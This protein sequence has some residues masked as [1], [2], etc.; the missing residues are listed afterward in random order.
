MRFCA[1]IRRR[2]REEQLEMPATAAPATV[3]HTPAPYPST[4]HTPEHYCPIPQRLITGLHDSPRAIGWYALIARL[5]QIAKQP[6]PLSDH[7]VVR[8]DPSASR[9]ASIRARERLLA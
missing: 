2:I 5:Y 3:F 4:A 6:V 7:D 8:Y 9:G 1:S